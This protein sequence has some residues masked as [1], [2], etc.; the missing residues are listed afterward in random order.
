[1]IPRFLEFARPH[2]R[3]FLVGFLLLVLTNALAL[4]IPWLLRDAVH[5][6]ERGAPHVLLAEYALG[7]IVLALLQAWVRTLSRLRILGAS[8]RIAFDIREAFFRKLERLDAA[9][10]DAT[11]TGDIMSRGVNDL[12]LLQSFYGPGVLNLL[13]TIIVYAAVAILLLRIDVTLTL[14]ALSVFPL[15]FFAV[16]RISRRV[17]AR[18]IAVQEQLAAISNRV[19]ENLSGIQQVKIYAQERREIAGFGEMCREFRSRNLALSRIRGLL[20]ATIGL[21]SG[22]GTIVV[23]YVGGRHVVAGTITLGDFVAYNA[24]LALLAWPTVA[25]G[26]IVNVFQRGAGAMQRL[27]EVL[28]AEPAIPPPS[29]DGAGAEPVPGD[30]EIRNLTFSYGDAAVPALE[31]VSLTIPRGSRIALVGPVG[32][33]KSTLVSLLARIY[34]APRGTIFLSGTDLLDLP[35]ARV[36]R[37]IGFVPQEAFLFSKPLR[38]NIALGRPDATDDEVD[39]AVALSHL[40]GDL[41]QL[42]EGLATVVGERGVTLSGGQRQ[43]ATLARAAV[44]EPPILILDDSLSSV[45]ADTERAILDEIDR[46]LSG[47]TLIFVSHR[48]SALA[49]VDR[50][51]V[52]DR[53]RIVEQGTHAELV[54]RGG[55]Y[56]GI[57]RKQ[58]LE[59]QMESE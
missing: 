51:V 21:W 1:M 19:Q 39:G 32:S 36:R 11:R 9:Y 29:L 54:E 25:L 47:R 3:A 28:R 35:V 44:V 8:R 34:P 23:L 41:P 55:V 13:N 52:L 53:G 16:N 12:Q 50:I 24:Y 22:L 5:A 56:A 45:D 59:A 4:G 18:S 10:Y 15:L 14:L 26:W 46:R 37:T 6:I 20:M 42:P 30:L 43:R 2:R 31:D 27:D 57:F 33:G 48:P 17:Y 40:A 38:D 49:G 58:I 7:M